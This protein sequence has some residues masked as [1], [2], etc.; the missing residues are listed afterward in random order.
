MHTGV[1]ARSLRRASSIATWPAGARETLQLD[2]DV[3]EITVG[4]DEPEILTGV[5]GARIEIRSHARVTPFAGAE[6]RALGLWGPRQ[7]YG[8]GSDFLLGR[9]RGSAIQTLT[10]EG[11]GG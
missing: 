2:S 10:G 1:T 3:S 6:L 7:R 4:A 9:R 5:E 8:G 11:R